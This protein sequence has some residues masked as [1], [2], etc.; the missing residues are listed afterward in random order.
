MRI[1]VYRPEVEPGQVR[2]TQVQ[3]AVGRPPAP[4]ALGRDRSGAALA[5]LGSVVTKFFEQQRDRQRR[6]AFNEAVAQVNNGIL[7]IEQGWNERKGKDASGITRDTQEAFARLMDNASLELDDYTKGEIGKW[8]SQTGL[9]LGRRAMRYE[10]SELNTYETES[11]TT[12]IASS[13]Q[14]LENVEILPNGLPDKADEARLASDVAAQLKGL[15]QHLGMDDE[16]Y[17]QKKTETISTAYATMI[18]RAIQNGQIPQAVELHK[19]R[20]QFLT[21]DDAARVDGEVRTAVVNMKAEDISAAASAKGTFEAGVAH[22][23]TTKDPEVR[24]EALKRFKNK[25]ILQQAIKEDN[26]AREDAEVL[27]NQGV[28]GYQPPQSWIDRQTVAE[29]EQWQLNHSQ[30]LSGVQGVF[31]GNQQEALDWARANMN[32]DPATT[33]GHPGWVGS[34]SEKEYRAIRNRLPAGRQEWFARQRTA[35]RQ[36]MTLAERAGVEDASASGGKGKDKALDLTDEPLAKSKRVFR[37]IAGA[38][39]SGPLTLNQARAYNRLNDRLSMKEQAFKA[40][41]GRSPT[42]FERNAMIDDIQMSYV[43]NTEGVDETVRVRDI[44]LKT[45]RAGDVAVDEDD[46]TTYEVEHVVPVLAQALALHS[47]TP[48]QKTGWLHTNPVTGLISDAGAWAAGF[49]ASGTE[50]RDELVGLR[51]IL[52]VRTAP[53]DVLEEAEHVMATVLG[54]E[55]GSDEFTKLLKDLGVAM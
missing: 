27:K 32:D 8:G 3:A 17:E 21:S 35:A 6:T 4:V 16:W 45:V 9:S 25:Y 22:V 54:L 18:G 10:D 26:E 31:N 2:P 55:H 14:M 41:N 49:F 29:F 30:M 39:T 37:S 44:T 28:P 11:R 52:H 1:Q 40:Q 20:R 53:D 24:A 36:A 19:E 5:Q 7:E 12:A 48:A 23:N 34:L 33:D 46:F 42:D 13:V 51:R 43:T 38:K 50:A 15:Q 47:P